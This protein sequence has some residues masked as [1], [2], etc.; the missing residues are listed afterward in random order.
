[1][2][3]QRRRGFFQSHCLPKC[4]L[5]SDADAIEA[6]SEEAFTQ[7]PISASADSITDE[8]LAEAQYPTCAMSHDPDLA[9]G[10]IASH[11]S[12]HLDQSH[13]PSS[14]NRDSTSNRDYMQPYRF[15]RCKFHQKKSRQ[16]PIVQP[17]LDSLSNDIEHSIVVVAN[18]PVDN[19][20][21]L[22]EDV[23]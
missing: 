21:K 13:L 2:T 22:Q 5:A 18:L 16:R 17:P 12:A 23:V 6:D 1:M 14:S 8:C 19:F 9:T 4:C 7:I 10:E 11:S 15:H 20:E 3:G